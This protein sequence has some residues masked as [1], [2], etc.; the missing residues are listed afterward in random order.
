M[1]AKSSQVWESRPWLDI[2]SLGYG[3][4]RNLNHDPN[5]TLLS[6]NPG[7]AHL[8]EKSFSQI[9]GKKNDP[10]SLTALF[11]YE[12]INNIRQNYSTGSC[13]YNKNLSKF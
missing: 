12:K 9:F 13:L 7:R 3:Q 5:P 6:N 1:C 2:L 4:D 10:L 11:H 8:A